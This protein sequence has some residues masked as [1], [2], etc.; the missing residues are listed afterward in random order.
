LPA[1]GVDRKPSRLRD[2]ELDRASTR[3]VG[4]VL[5]TVHDTEPG[6]ATVARLAREMLDADPAGTPG[7]R[8]V[9]ERLGVS[10]AHLV[11]AFARCYG[12]PPHRYLVGR[13]LDLARRRLLAGEAAAHVAVDTGFYDQ[14][15]LTRHFTRCSPPHRR[16]TSGAAG[17]PAR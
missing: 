2:D 8:A 1:V 3:T 13:R 9:A 12:I 10:T 5:L 17:R 4:G 11:R 14:A 16:A 15:H 6:A 7:V